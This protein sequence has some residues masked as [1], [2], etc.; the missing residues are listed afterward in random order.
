M[1]VTIQRGRTSP[2]L[3]TVLL[4]LLNAFILLPAAWGGTYGAVVVCNMLSHEDSFPPVSEATVKALDEAGPIE[5]QALMEKEFKANPAFRQWV[6]ETS[7]RY[8]AEV[9]WLVVLPIMNVSLY[10]LLGFLLGATGCSRYVVL[11]PVASL[12]FSI[13][14]LWKNQLFSEVPNQDLAVGVAVF[15][16]FVG[17]FVGAALGRWARRWRPGR[18]VHAAP[19]G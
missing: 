11:V 5:T 1:D 14:I 7:M 19:V 12:Y 17:I 4:A 9:N 18:A 16:Q 8:I 13:A 15:C 10:L 6:V 2:I 3:V